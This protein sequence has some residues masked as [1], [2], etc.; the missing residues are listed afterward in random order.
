MLLWM[1]IRQSV[2]MRYRQERPSVLL[3]KQ[4]A[5]GLSFRASTDYYFGL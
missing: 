3:P 2:F 5:D 1:E 4:A